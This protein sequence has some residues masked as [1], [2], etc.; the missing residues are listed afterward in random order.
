M[1][2][3]A[4]RLALSPCPVLALLPDLF[5]FCRRP[6]SMSPVLQNRSGAR[7]Y[8]LV[9]IGCSKHAEPA[10]PAVIHWKGQDGGYEDTTIVPPEKDRLH[11]DSKETRC[12]HTGLLLF[13]LIAAFSISS[14]LFGPTTMR[15][16][17]LLLIVLAAASSAIFVLPRFLPPGTPPPVIVHS[18]G[19]TIEKLERLSQL[20]TLRVQVADILSPR[21][22]AAAVA[23]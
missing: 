11:N 6:C 4:V 12:D 20:V 22:K 10:K 17:T 8:R 14:Y 9:C 18:Q 23:G 15:P 2:A 3:H 16:T 13:L 5:Y 7:G 1:T 19:P 21:A